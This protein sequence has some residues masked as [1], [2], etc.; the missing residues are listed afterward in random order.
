MLKVWQRIGVAPAYSRP[1]HARHDPGIFVGRAGG[2]PRASE[3][4]ARQRD[5]V[6]PWTRRTEDGTPGGFYLQA[7]SAIRLYSAARDLSRAPDQHTIESGVQLCGGS[8]LSPSSHVPAA[9]GASK[10]GTYGM[11]PIV[12]NHTGTK[13]IVEL[14]GVGIS[15]YHSRTASPKEER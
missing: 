4:C 11:L 6:Q 3:G 7:C 15:S 2:P 8:L 13:R 9:A 10:R 5:V 1:Q 14:S 12:G